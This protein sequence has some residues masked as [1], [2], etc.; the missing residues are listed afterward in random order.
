MNTSTDVVIIGGGLAG[1]TAA[2]QLKRRIPEL[3]IEIIERQRFP[4]AEA[5]YKVGE[6]SVEIGSHYFNH[7]LD[8]AH[9]LIPSKIPKLGLRYFFPQGDNQATHL[10]PELGQTHY[11]AVGSTQFDRGRQEN[12]LREECLRLGVR[13]VDGAKVTEVDLDADGEH[14]VVY[15]TG[16]EQHER[17]VRWVIDASGRPGVLKRK[18]GLAERNDHQV[19]A[20]WFRIDAGLAV[21]DL[22]DDPAWQARVP[23]SMRRLSTNH[24]MGRG[25]WVWF[26]P[27]A[28]GSISIGIV[29]DPAFHP[30]AKINTLE[31][32][33]AWLGEFEPAA[34][35]LIEAHA[36][37]VADFRTMKHFSHGAKQCFCA[38]RWAL[39]GEAG[40]FLDPFYSPGSDF[41]AISNGFITELVAADY[42]GQDIAKLA[43]GYDRQYLSLYRS[44][45]LLY[46]GQ[47]GM[48]GNAHVMTLKVVFDYTGYWGST[49]LLWF[50]GRMTDP[51]FVKSVSVD[52]LQ[53]FRLTQTA[54]QLFRDWNA[55]DPGD[56]A[57][58]ASLNY[59]TLEFLAEWQS[60]LLADYDDDGL[61]R[62]LRENRRVMELVLGWLYTRAT[63]K[64]AAN[65]YKARIG[66]EP[67]AVVVPPGGLDMLEALNRFVND[68]TELRDGIRTVA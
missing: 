36:D 2:I 3:P 59:Q 1:A 42:E 13:F 11:H 48:F 25:Y 4:V 27:L 9:A 29:A 50:A 6:S 22:S 15:T 12:I 23:F 21:D 38:D 26:I 45:L 33:K 43:K 49:A 67:G 34:L 20:S 28:N 56:W 58:P 37:K 62:L 39:T 47:Y 55:A 5:A 66:D 40:V 7:T 8:L 53:V 51:A 54:Q 19:N 41:I 63:G 10:R 61:R 57:E 44:F 60:A 35:G 14:R 46:Q 24:F 18:L 32:A 68:K 65:I 52:L 16:D 30:F 64:V 31:R 17:R